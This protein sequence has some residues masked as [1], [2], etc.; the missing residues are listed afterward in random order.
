VKPI[1]PQLVLWNT[2]TGKQQ[3]STTM[4]LHEFTSVA[5]SPDGMLI[6][7]GHFFSGLALWDA[8]SGALLRM[9]DGHITEGCRRWGCNPGSFEDDD[10]YAPRALRAASGCGSAVQADIRASD[11]ARSELPSCSSISIRPD[12]R[13]G[14][15]RGSRKLV[16]CSW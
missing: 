13:S 9:L 5:F 3:W 16:S 7:S 1:D 8:Q 11:R 6:A 15:L 12:R 4:E 14:R 10:G 2:L